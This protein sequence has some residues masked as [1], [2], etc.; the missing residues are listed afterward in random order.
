M[1]PD[2]PYD[3][4]KVGSRWTPLHDGEKPAHGYAYDGTLPGYGVGGHRFIADLPPDDRRA[5]LEYLKT[6]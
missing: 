5:V 6:L 3:V 2:A 1:D 4:A